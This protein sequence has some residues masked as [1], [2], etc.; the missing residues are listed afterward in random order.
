MPIPSFA[1][2]P[3]RIHRGLETVL[4]RSRGPAQTCMATSLSIS[5]SPV[6]YPSTHL[7]EA[8]A[9]FFFIVAITASSG[10]S[11]DPVAIAQ[12]TQSDAGRA[13]ESELVDKL[14]R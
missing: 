8:L 10:P 4:K 2:G 7:F 11:P 6:P 3:R 12:N 13:A 9:I 14:R 5:N 1:S